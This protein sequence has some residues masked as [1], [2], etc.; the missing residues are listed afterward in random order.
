M[1]RSMNDCIGVE[2]LNESIV[3]SY[4]SEL[5]ANEFASVENGENAITNKREKWRIHFLYKGEDFVRVIA[6]R[7]HAWGLLGVCVN[8]SHFRG[9][10]TWTFKTWKHEAHFWCVYFA[11]SMGRYGSLRA[12]R[13]GMLLVIT[14]NQSVCLPI[15]ILAVYLTTHLNKCK[16]NQSKNRIV[17]EEN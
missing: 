1:P 12:Y 10:K 4:W 5:F 9:S 8:V 7:S 6:T 14:R 15:S 11:W 16:S 2:L 13:Y 3:L 17:F